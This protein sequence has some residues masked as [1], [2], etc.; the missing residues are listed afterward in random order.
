MAPSYEYEKPL[1]GLMPREIHRQHRALEI[2]EAMT[3]YVR[4]NKAIPQEWLDELAEL[5]GAA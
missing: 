1:I 4:A 5:C 3:R 2:I